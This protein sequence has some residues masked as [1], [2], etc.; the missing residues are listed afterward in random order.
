VR[1]SLPESWGAL[2]REA[3]PDRFVLEIRNA[4]DPLQAALE[5]KRPERFIGVIYLP[6]TERLSHYAGAS[7]ARQFDAY[8]WFETTKA[9]EPLLS[10]EIEAMPQTYPFAM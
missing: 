8:V 1:P 10:A 3:D 2:M 9:V 4:A 5:P 6:E 7:L